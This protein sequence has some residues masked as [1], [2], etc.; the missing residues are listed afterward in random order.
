M[1]AKLVLYIFSYYWMVVNGLGKMLNF[2]TEGFVK[3]SLLS[4]IYST[5]KQKNW[6]LW[7]TPLAKAWVFHTFAMLECF[8]NTVLASFVI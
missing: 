8:T 2:F 7:S 6:R 3:F 5:F 1:L 4:S